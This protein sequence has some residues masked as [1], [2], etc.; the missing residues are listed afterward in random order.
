MPSASAPDATTTIGMLKKEHSSNKK[1]DKDKN[2]NTNDLGGNTNPSEEIK[3]LPNLSADNLFQLLTIK[4]N[5][6]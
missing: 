2:N 4:S 1:R 3:T 6:R 5:K